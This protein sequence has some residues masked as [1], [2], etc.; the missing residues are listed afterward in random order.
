MPGWLLVF[1][2]AEALTLSLR[3]CRRPRACAL[4]RLRAAAEL[5]VLCPKPQAAEVCFACACP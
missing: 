1:D 3:S 5:R 2:N 4:G